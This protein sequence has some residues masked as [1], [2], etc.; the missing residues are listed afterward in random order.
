MMLY[1]KTLSVC[2]KGTYKLFVY[3]S[4][5]DVNLSNVNEYKHIIKTNIGNMLSCRL[6]HW[7]KLYCLKKYLL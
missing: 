5:Q 3:I 7:S 6:G 4:E 2:A 1:S